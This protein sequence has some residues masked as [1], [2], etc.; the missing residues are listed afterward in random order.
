MAAGKFFT[1]NKGMLNILNGNIKLGTHTI[2]AIPLQ[3]TYTPSTASHSDV[4]QLTAF[5]ST[6]SGSVVNALTVGSIAIT[7]SS[8]DT[9]KIDG[10]DL[11]G[12]SSGG[13]TIVSCKYV[14]LYAESASNGVGENLLWGFFNVDE[15][16][17]SASLGN[18]TQIN[19]TWNSNG[20]CKYRSNQ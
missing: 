5:R 17:A 14:A 3:D 15:S 11:S 16:G 1:Y 6:A 20:I 2:K 18:S 7:T 13:D 8:V 12:F 10:A 4:S 9:V 19:V